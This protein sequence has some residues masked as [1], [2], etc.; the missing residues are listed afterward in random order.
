MLWSTR[1][2]KAAAAI[3]IAIVA[4]PITGAIEGV[5]SAVPPPAPALVSPADGASVTIPVTISWSQ[6]TGAGG[7]NWEI[8]L[9]ADFASVLERNP[10]L[11]VGTA[12]TQDVV[13]GLP[14]GT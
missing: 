12:T 9:T 1:T 14:N 11:L 13:S 10:T 8:S 2:R 5:A 4:M 7:Y 6:V 3:L